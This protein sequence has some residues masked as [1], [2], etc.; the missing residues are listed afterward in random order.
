M[1]MITIIKNKLHD[2]RN[3]FPQ[4][5]SYMSVSVGVKV[6]NFGHLVLHVYT[7]HGTINNAKFKQ[8]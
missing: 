6:N 5:H 7:G 4:C 2:F 1:M 8:V 3:L